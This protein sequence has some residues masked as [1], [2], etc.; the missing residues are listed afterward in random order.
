MSWPIL[1]GGMVV[2]A[3]LLGRPLAPSLDSASLVLL[4]S[5]LV[6]E[7]LAPALPRFGFV[8]AASG[9][10][11][12]LALQGPDRCWLAAFAALG[13][14]LIRSL[15]SQQKGSLLL[16]ESLAEIQPLWLALGL[17]Q[18]ALGRLWLAPFLWWL[19][20]HFQPAYLAASLP[21]EVAR[22][23][24]LYRARLGPIG[25][26]LALAASFS[27]W[28]P[29]LPILRLGQALLMQCLV[30]TTG[31]VV[32]GVDSSQHEIGQR[33]RERG[34]RQQQVGLEQLEQGLQ[35]TG[36]AQQRTQAELEVRLETYQMVEEMLATI[37][38]RPVFQAVADMVVARVQQRFRV[39]NVVLFWKREGLVPVAWLSPQSE[40]LETASLT[41]SGEPAAEQALRTQQLQLGTPAGQGER[42]F[43]EDRWTVG[44]PLGQRGSLYLGHAQERRLSPEDQHFL[45]VLS[46]HSLLALEAAGWYQTLQEAL[47]GEAAAAAKNE[48]LVQRLALVI[49]GVTQLIRLREPQAMLESA[50]QI[51]KPLVEHETFFACSGN[52][53]V[54]QGAPP[55]DV[56]ALAQK[57]AEQ[58]LPLLLEQ[59]AR[60]AV[61]L[62]SE[63]GCLGG[64][65]LART[66]GH[67]SRAD[68][69]IL[70]VLS[71][72]LGSALV[73]AQLYA[74]LKTT[75]QALRD[76]QAQLVQSSK[77][78]AV[79]Q[80]AGGVAHELN[81][82]LGAVALAIEAAQMSLTT[83]PDRA[84]ARLERAGKAVQQMK[85]IVSKLLFYSR[86]AR[87]GWRETD[88]NA[89]LDDTLQL[90]GHQLRIDGIEVR[91]QYGELPAIMGNPNELQQVFTNLILNARD[92]MLSPGATGKQ[93]LISTGRWEGGVWGRVQDQGCGM[94][95]QVKERIFEPFFTTKEVGKGT[96][97]GL[98]VTS[99]LV[100]QHQGTVQVDSRPGV[101]T[102]F[103]VRLPLSAGPE[104]PSS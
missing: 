75:H 97:L 46:R 89:V 88:L 57:V 96:G 5:G 84:Q 45:Q 2:G 59:P 103:E 49:D 37:P 70:A 18:G 38:Q 19:L 72:Q 68:Q 44:V 20:W 81:T 56:E 91:C 43:P 73:T 80:L 93:L 27:A 31:A 15:R 26:G 12:A 28:L 11:L 62:L 3:G 90:V 67:F 61:P 39:H 83:K 35:A 104:E 13:A 71:Y 23:W 8:S 34:L 92:A 47:R 87:S 9:L 58:G 86:D 101:G 76:S 66:V 33:Q 16:L 29:P 17:A 21:R 74:E 36:A 14:A 40:R 7:G 50:A 94:D 64:I 95:E 69:D 41:Q 22:D 4:V 79:G 48:A 25:L 65:V 82:P 6:F 1:L 99:Q 102:R 54:R 78:A 10:W 53:Q 60:L 51:L 77:M 98:S 42:I 100:A 24:S 30:A 55:G 63:R 52:H 85:E 32:K